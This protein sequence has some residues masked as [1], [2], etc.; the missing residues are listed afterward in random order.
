MAADIGVR[1]AIEG[2]QKFKTEIQD[3]TQSQKTLKSEMAAVSSAWDK[4]TSAEK[5]NAEQKRIL[6]QQIEAQKQKV[7]ALQ[8]VVDKTSAKYGENSREANSWKEKLNSATA[9]LNNL[10]GQLDN[11]PSGIDM[12]SQKFTDA[13]DK[14]SGAG[15]KIKGVGDGMTKYITA[16]IAAIGA[17]SIVAFNDVDSGLDTIITKTGASGEALESMQNSMEEIATTIPT[18]FDEAGAAVGEVNTRFGVMG[19][20]LTDLS[21][22]FIKF[23]QLNGT[24][25]SGSID[26]VQS[27]M[28]AFGIGAEDAGK[29][30][31]IL[32]KAGQDT[33]ISMDA[34]AS[35]LTANGT[36]MQE[37]G[38]SFEQSAGFIANLSKNGIDASA[39]M[40]GM[41][42][43]LQTAA[44]EGK[45]LD[46]ALA[47]LQEKMKGAKDGTEAMQMAMELFGNKAGPQLAKAIQEGRISLDASANSVKDFGDSVSK[48]FD[49]TLDPPDKLKT[50]FNEL[51]LIG[52]DLGG[53]LL[54]MLVP[55]LQK[56]SEIVHTA[57]DAWN[58]LDEGQKQTIIT[59]AAVVAAIGPIISV[60]GSVVIGIG[61]MITAVGTITGAL[62]AIGPVVAG[63]VAAFGPFVAIG[64]AVVAAG[65]AIYNNWDVIKEKAQELATAVGEKF[66]EIKTAAQEKWQAANEAVSNAME[67]VKAK[68]SEGMAVAKEVAAGYLQQLVEEYEKSGGGMSG[69]IEAAMTT[70]KQIFDDA[71][72]Y[73]NEITGGKF[74]EIVNTI[75]TNLENLKAEFTEKFDNVKQIVS[76]AVEFLKGIF[77][78]EWKLPDIKLPHFKVSGQ[79]SLDPPSFPT[80]GVDWYAKA[81]GGGVILN[82]PTIFGMS[83]GNLLGAGEA[84]AEVVVGAGSLSRMIQNAVSNTYNSGG[85]TINVYGA[86]GQDVHELAEAIADI[87]NGDIQSKG[88]VWA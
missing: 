67:S 12:L 79:F 71:Y 68:V 3:I 8:E 33:G 36:A 39:V 77:D 25:V 61:S 63:V 37:A 41:K 44:K 59:I 87:I 52:A 65:V 53:T 23:A 30:L 46:E 86:P 83:G 58:N 64:A 80:F 11:L 51:K 16:P 2:Y 34:L 29:V 85:N 38:F 43:A 18:G 9:E 88:A 4:N 66:D 19:D 15:E 7:Q 26:K 22:Q 5:K 49:A 57:R 21:G 45:P 55:A 35:A 70:A 72:A 76:D 28:A 47:E 40:T 73:I 6:N 84:G 69:A 27:S 74:G 14:I 10:K 50:T 48:T 20:D 82:S 31:D 78:F 54:E 75:K 62:G 42:K 13:G 24:D 56:L 32:N 81:M 60:I 1:V 17:A